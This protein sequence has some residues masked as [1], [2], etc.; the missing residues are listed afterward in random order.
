MEEEYKKELLANGVDVP[1]V[2]EPETKEPAQE[3]E[4]K[5]PKEDLPETPKEKRSIYDE[6]KDKKLELKEE[7]ERREVVEQELAELRQKLDK[8]DTPKEKEAVGDEF[9]EFAKEI[10]ADPEALRKMRALFLKDV[11]P[12]DDPDLKK[13]LEEFKAWKSQNQQAIETQ[14]FEKE[15]SQVA[16]ALKELFPDATADEINDIKKELDSLSHTKEMHDKELDY[17]IFKHKEDLK[18]FVSPKKRGM[19]SKERQDINSDTIDFNPEADY[20]KM[21]AKEREQWEAAY[22]NLSKREGLTEDA[23]G[24]MMFI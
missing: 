16:P 19:E 17:V 5:E 23:S 20:S 1:D 8:A 24:K 2:K 13:D 21:T 6:Y 3:P 9:E 22:K 4:E 10:N 11:K 14:A 18:A 15:F 12:S 7:R